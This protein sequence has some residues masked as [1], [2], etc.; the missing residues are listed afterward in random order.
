[1]KKDSPIN[2]KLKK[3]CAILHCISD[4]PPKNKSINMSYLNKLKK[5]SKLPV[6]FSD[7][8]LGYEA[9]ILAIGQGATIIEKHVRLKETDKKSPDFKNS[10][11]FSTFKDFVKKCRASFE[12]LGS[13][14]IL[15]KNEIKLRKKTFSKSIL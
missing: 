2:K 3:N 9:S 12:M 14:K 6:G 13:Q 15:T 10:M 11:E 4:Y 8:T 1:M 7:H 5:I